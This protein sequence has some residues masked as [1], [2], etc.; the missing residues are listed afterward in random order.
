M[1]KCVL[2]T[3]RTCP[4]GA[5][6]HRTM[7]HGDPPRREVLCP[8]CPSEGARWPAGCPPDRAGQ[9][10]PAPLDPLPCCPFPFTHS[11]DTLVSA[12]LSPPGNPYNYEP[13]RTEPQFFPLSNGGTQS[14]A[15]TSYL[16]PRLLGQPRQARESEYSRCLGESTALSTQL[17]LTGVTLASS[18]PLSGGS[19]WRV[20]CPLPC[21]L[22]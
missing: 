14:S 2:R 6:T 18:Q 5:S 16:Y 15:G 11:W 7:E 3:S 13:L 10:F 21:H 1:N 8:H 12:I 22:P 9:L 17:S 19:S 20:L 4:P